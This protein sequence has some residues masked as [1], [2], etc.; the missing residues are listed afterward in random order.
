[1][2]FTIQIKHDTA[3]RTWKC[4]SVVSIAPDRLINEAPAY[5]V[6]YADEHAMNPDQ[7]GCRVLE[8]DS[9]QI[10]QR[11]LSSFRRVVFTRVS[12]ASA[13]RALPAPALAASAEL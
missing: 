11:T 3:H 5:A 4:L 9:S 2:P 8:I 6:Q 7:V 13:N 1:M 12:A 10:G